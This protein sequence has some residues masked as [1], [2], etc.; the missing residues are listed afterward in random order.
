MRKFSIL[1]AED[2]A[3]DRFL[4][5]KAFEE[6]KAEETVAFVENGIKA[7]EFL[8]KIRDANHVFPNLII[9]DLNMPFRDGKEV[10][11]EIKEDSVLKKI[12]VLV[13]STSSN[14]AIIDKCYELGA[15]T[16]IVKPLSFERLLK[17]VQQIKSYWLQI[18]SL[19][20]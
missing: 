14:E 3:D 16:Y 17:A 9:L 10:L 13:L 7:L 11:R 8:K 12:P 5:K 19:P 1:I 18:A 20:L 15:N 4:L 6:N 2:D